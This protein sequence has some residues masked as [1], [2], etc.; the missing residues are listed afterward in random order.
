MERKIYIV[1]VNKVNKLSNLFLNR[2]GRFYYHFK[3]SHLTPSEMEEFCRSCLNNIDTDII[4]KLKLIAK[5]NK[6]NYDI[7]SAITDE[8]NN[9]YSLAESIK[10]LNVEIGSGDICYDVTVQYDNSE[11][12]SS[13]YLSS[14][15]SIRCNLRKRTNPKFDIYINF[16]FED[17]VLDNNNNGT[18]IIPKKSINEC[19]LMDRCGQKD[20]LDTISDITLSPHSYKTC[21]VFD[22]II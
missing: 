14:D 11:Y 18:I 13:L 8:L 21:N 12:S 2:P 10:D 1:A 3:F 5:Y 20:I 15:D 7:A 22:S 16:S 6:I 4:N 19:M 9:G 17:A